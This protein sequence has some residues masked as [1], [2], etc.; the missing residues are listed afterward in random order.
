MQQPDIDS[1]VSCATVF[2][3]HQTETSIPR[4][5][6]P[7][8]RARHGNINPLLRNIQ[9]EQ[10]FPRQQ[11][12]STVVGHLWGNQIVATRCLIFDRGDLLKSE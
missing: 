11:I 6:L 9:A 3:M 10:I 7:F 12:L 8:E 2:R 4:Q 1:D 5:R